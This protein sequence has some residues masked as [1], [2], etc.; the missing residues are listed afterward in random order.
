MKN[1]I[2]PYR[3]LPAYIISR[4]IGLRVFFKYKKLL[5]IDILLEKHISRNYRNAVKNKR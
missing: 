2:V 1:D 4:K 3:E 5:C